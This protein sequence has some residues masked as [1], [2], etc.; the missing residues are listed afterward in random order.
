MKTILV[1]ASE[2]DVQEYHLDKDVMKLSEMEK[3]IRGKILRESLERSV[4]HAEKA[5]LSKM[6]DE[7]INQIIDEVRKGA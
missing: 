6:T 1:E 7:E 3:L 2:E 4:E 5:G